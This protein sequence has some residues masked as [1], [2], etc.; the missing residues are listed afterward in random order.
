M[1]SIDETAIKEFLDTDHYK[2]SQ[3]AKPI[4]DRIQK[5]IPIQLQWN[6][7]TYY[8]FDRTQRAIGRITYQ[9]NNVNGPIKIGL[10]PSYRN[11]GLRQQMLNTLSHELAHLGAIRW[12][13][14]QGHGYYWSYLMIAMG[15]E[16]S[17]NVPSENLKQIKKARVA[18]NQPQ[19]KFMWC[20]SC[21]KD[22]LFELWEDFE[23][24]CQSCQ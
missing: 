10:D 18:E 4:I 13:K 12:M 23:Y 2:I 7:V 11:P 3:E 20:N 14:E 9:I 6:N 17:R 16:P 19:F 22:K 8:F 1:S 21:G 5:L 24:H 15:Y